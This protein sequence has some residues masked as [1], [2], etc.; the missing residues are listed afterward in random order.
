[1]KRNN[2]DS[3]NVSVT[4]V[5]V[6]VAGLTA[7]ATASHR[8]TNYGVDTAKGVFEQLSKAATPATQPANPP[9]VKP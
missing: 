4:G 2:Q 3:S 5:I 8:A 7:L 1:M 6:G 9:A